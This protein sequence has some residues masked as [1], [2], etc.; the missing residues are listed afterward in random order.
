MAKVS[1]SDFTF[2]ASS[3][4]RRDLVYVLAHSDDGTTVPGTYFAWKGKFTG[5]NDLQFG[6]TKI[7]SEPGIEVNVIGVEG[8]WACVR[9]D[10]SGQPAMQT[11]TIDS[12]PNGPGVR[13]WIRDACRVEGRLYAVGMSRQAYERAE[14]Y[15]W[16]RIDG[17]ILSQK[18]GEPVG[19][20]GVDGFSLKEIYAAGLKGEIWRFNGSRWVSMPSPTN[21]QLNAVRC[22]GEH[23]Y[24]VGGSGVVLWGRAN[25]FS[26]LT[27]QRDEPN[28][29][30]IE[31]LGNEI[32]VA[33]PKTLYR[34]RDKSLSE[35][36]TKLG[37]ITTGS[38]SSRDGVMWSVGAKHL[39]WT[40]DGKKWTQVFV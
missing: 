1:D 24:I 30:A 34:L 17:D 15:V 18:P 31:S 40:D 16:R 13:G 27:I 19:L 38:L 12:G 9:K 35:V 5:Q 21:V 4:A 6:P 26:V 10:P 36:N 32:Y 3:V 29:Y 8:E 20:N 25:R 39:I 22:I 23:V 37:E 2:V 33:S 11:G 14:D 28:L 7:L